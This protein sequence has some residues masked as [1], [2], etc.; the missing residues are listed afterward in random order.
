MRYGRL[1]KVAPPSLAGEGK[2]G[3]YV[4][5]TWDPDETIA[6]VKNAAPAGSI[7][8]IVGQVSHPLLLALGIHPGK[9]T[10]V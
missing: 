2:D 9:V 5:G 6:L 7:V 3:L 8:Q 10:R 4:V 1:V